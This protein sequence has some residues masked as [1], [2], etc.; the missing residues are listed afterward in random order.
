MFKNMVRCGIILCI[1]FATSISSANPHVEKEKS[2]KS[3]EESVSNDLA[4]YLLSQEKLNPKAFLVPTVL[5]YVETPDGGI[6]QL[7]HKNQYKGGVMGDNT[8]WFQNDKRKKKDT[9]KKSQ[10]SPQAK[11]KATKSKT[12]TL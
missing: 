7:Q 5:V 1:A 9:T 11:R 4:F 12:W 6:I 3:F 2:E 8:I 10:S